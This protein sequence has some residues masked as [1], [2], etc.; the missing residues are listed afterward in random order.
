MDALEDI[1]QHG[2][3][4]RSTSGKNCREV[5]QTQESD[6]NCI[7][8]T[9]CKS[10]KY[11]DFA[12][13]RDAGL[14]V[15]VEIEFDCLNEAG[16]L[17]DEDYLKSLGGNPQFEDTDALHQHL[18]QRMRTDRSLWQD[19][20]ARNHTVAYE[21]TVPTS[22]ISRISVFNPELSNQHSA[23]AFEA[24]RIDLNSAMTDQKIEKGFELTSAMLG[25][26]FDPLRIYD[27]VGCYLHPCL[28]WICPLGSSES[29]EARDP[30]DP[31]HFQLLWP[32]SIAQLEVCYAMERQTK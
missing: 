13:R 22:A 5:D 31:C 30:S 14:P 6:P 2:L 16:L 18:R 12:W 17:P 32:E 23:V 27:S 25:D 26:S 10:P 29:I 4:P 9:D 7:Y 11:A 24:D 28:G 1:L 19:S 20:L 15:I 8:L 21:G 3:Q